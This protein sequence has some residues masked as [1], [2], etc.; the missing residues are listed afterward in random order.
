MN[1]NNYSRYV[2]AQT[3]MGPNSMRI[4]EALLAR[5]PVV[6]AP[7]AVALDLGCGTG[8]TSLVIA[9][10]TGAKVC[11]NDL[12]IS[13]EDNQRRFEEWGVAGQVIPVHEDAH[14]LHFDRPAFDALFSIDAYHY[15]AGDPSFFR[16]KILPFMKDGS[17]ALIGV[18]GIKD[19]YDGRSEELLVD[20][21][22][23]EAHMFK[24]PRRWR[25]ILGTDA[26]IE[27]VDTWELDCFDAAWEEWFAS[28]HE[29]ARGDRRFY[30]TLIVPYT[31]FVGIHVQMR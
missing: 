7:D 15:F 2:S 30:E 8:L 22:G 12:W 19:A 5:Y 31:C 6:L 17:V 28:D 29:F 9:R 10:E 26:R 4:L 14:D 16:T 25:E 24:S 20:W 3:M 1:Y 18:P 11:A 23:D 21:L 27:R 13:A